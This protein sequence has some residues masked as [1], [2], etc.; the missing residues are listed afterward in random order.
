MEG[1]PFFR[2]CDDTFLSAVLC[3]MQPILYAPTEIIIQ[4]GQCE[5]AM[6]ILCQ[7]RAG[8]LNAETG[9][10]D[11]EFN[12]GAYFGEIALFFKVPR[13]ATIVATSFCDAFKLNNEPFEAVM[14]QYPKMKKKVNQ[15][16]ESMF[17]ERMVCVNCGEKGHTGAVCTEL[18]KH[19]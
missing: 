12:K 7:G 10:I 2:G 4:K 8:L 9:G 16:A 13:T 15:L 18:G 17:T 1:V 11:V 3:A 14:N 19:L 5:L 6:Y